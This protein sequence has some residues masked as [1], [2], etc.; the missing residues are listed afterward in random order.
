MASDRETQMVSVERLREYSE[1]PVEASEDGYGEGDAEGD[2]GDEAEGGEGGEG[3]GGDGGDGRAGVGAFGGRRPSGLSW[4]AHGA[5]ELRGLVLR[6]R[7]GL[8][9]VIRG[10]SCSIKGGEK[11]GVCGRTGAGKS[12]LILGLLR[13]VEADSGCIRIDGVDISTLSLDFLRHSVAVI[14][15]D[16]V[17]F[18]GTV[19]ESR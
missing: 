10:L 18:S 7:P 5:V 1:I 2:E 4:P 11:V 14:P 12:S 9:P 17:L 6:Y 3:D 8:A 16:P 15:Q 13:I 19:R